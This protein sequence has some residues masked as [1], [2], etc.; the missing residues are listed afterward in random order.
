MNCKREKGKLYYY[1]NLSDKT[2][3]Y[4]INEGK[5]AND[6]RQYVN[7]PPFISTNAFRKRGSLRGEWEL[8]MENY[9]FLLAAKNA[10]LDHNDRN[11]SVIICKLLDRLLNVLP[12]DCTPTVRINA[13]MEDDIVELALKN[14][15]F[16]TYLVKYIQDNYN[17]AFTFGHYLE[18]AYHNYDIRNLAICDNDY[19][20][21]ECLQKT[22]VVSA[23]YNLAKEYHEIIDFNTICYYLTHGLYDK[24][25]YRWRNNQTYYDMERDLSQ[26]LSMCLEMDYHPPKDKWMVVDLAVRKM[27]YQ[28]LDNKDR[29]PLNLNPALAYHND[30]FTVVIPNNILDYRQEADR[31]Q[32]CVYSMY[33]PK[34]VRKETQV[35]FVRRNDD[36]E[37][38]YITCEVRMNGTIAQYLFAN[39]RPVKNDT[40][41][42]EFRVEYQNYLNKVF[43]KE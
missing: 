6:S 38:S 40:P 29:E 33:A 10:D 16:F 22:R 9:L 11:N 5:F 4:D 35:V 32:N 20:G 2:A 1:D 12:A 23:F 34:V 19:Y 17:T 15:T 14:K 21:A 36:L 42:W 37:N 27:Y 43:G 31:Q 28:F 39:N 41:E 8:S 24:W 3:W 26:L 25:A 13:I 30:N 18:S 7:L